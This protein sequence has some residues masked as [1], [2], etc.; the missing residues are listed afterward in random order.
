MVMTDAVTRLLP[1]VLGKDASSDEESFSPKYKI[2]DTSPVLLEYPHFTRP[3][4][5][6]PISQARK[7]PLVVPKVLMSGHHGE[8]E[9]WRQSEALKRTKKRRPDLLN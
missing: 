8:I 4:S 5:Y 2:L 1:G 3:L 6:H 9:K 7:R